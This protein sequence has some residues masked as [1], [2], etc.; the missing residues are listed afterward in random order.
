LPK[1][2]LLLAVG[3]G[4]LCVHVA[5]IANASVGEVG[6]LPLATRA[7]VQPP[8]GLPVERLS[9]RFLGARDADAGVD[10]RSVIGRAAGAVAGR[11]ELRPILLTAWELFSSQVIGKTRPERKRPKRPPEGP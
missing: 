10:V 7:R 5:N 6:H 9:D 11:E 8:L 4:K 1:R 2:T 3:I